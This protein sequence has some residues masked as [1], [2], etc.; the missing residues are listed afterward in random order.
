MTKLATSSGTVIYEDDNKL[1][2]VKKP[3][4]W[5]STALFVIGLLAIIILANGILQLFILDSQSRI[6]EPVGTILVVAGTLFALIFWRVFSYRK[7]MNSKP[8]NELECICI[9]DLNNNK[10]MDAKQNI[11]APLAEVTL[12]R[13][14]Q[15]T[16][17][18]ASLL[19]SWHTNALKIVEGNP[20]S[21]GIEAVENVLIAKGIKR[22]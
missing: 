15:I 22:K 1:R 12:Q 8:V 18:S 3:A 11:L 4:L 6:A 19:L 10:L 9:I 5:T 16:S 7:K 14:M 21:G 13:K 20:F 17:S 2:L